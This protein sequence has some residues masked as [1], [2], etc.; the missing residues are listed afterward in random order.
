MTRGGRPRAMSKIKFCAVIVLATALAGAAYAKGGGGGGH[1]G[2]GGGRG[3]GGG[4]FGGGAHVGGGGPFG[5]ARIGGA[6]FR[7]PRTRRAHF[8]AG[9]VGRDPFAGASL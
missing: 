1:G 3:G 6:R 9:R 5:R 8:C 4:H 7:G 2:G